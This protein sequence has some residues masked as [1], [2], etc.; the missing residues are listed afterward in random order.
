MTSDPGVLEPARVLA[1]LTLEQ[2]WFNYFAIG[3]GSSVDRIAEYLS[4]AAVPS[5]LEYDHLAQAINDRFV[6]LGLDHPVPYS[7]RP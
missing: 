1:R 3:G 4:G 5:D 2:L 7:R 6:E